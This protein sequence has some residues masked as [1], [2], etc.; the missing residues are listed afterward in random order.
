MNCK[1]E[2]NYKT[3]ISLFTRK[4]VDS[5]YKKH[6]EKVLLERERALLPAT[7]PIVEEQQRQETIKKEDFRRTENVDALSNS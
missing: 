7:Q 5:V 3:L 4:F 6:T 2:W 1:H